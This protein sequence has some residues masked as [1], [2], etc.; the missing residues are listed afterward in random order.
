MYVL[1]DYHYD[2]PEERIAQVPV[3][4]RDQSRLLV[5]NR[6]T[7]KTTHC[8]FSDLPDLLLAGDLLVINNTEVIPARLFGKKESGGKAELLFLDF[9]EAEGKR[10]GQNT[11]V[12]R[13]LIKSAKR[14]RPGT[15]LRFDDRF[16]GRVREGKNGVY[17]VEFAFEGDFMEALHR[18]GHIPLPPYIR[19]KAGIPDPV[20]VRSYQT[21]YASRKGAVAAPTAGLHF[22]P[23]LLKNLAQKGVLTAEITLH[24]GYGTFLP[25]RVTDIRNHR[26]DAERYNVSKEAAEKIREAKDRGSRIVA[27]GTTCVRTLEYASDPKGEVV[28]GSGGCDLFI[29]PGCRFKVVE[30]LITNFHLPKSTLLMLVSAFAGRERILAA[31]REAVERRYRFY[32]FGDAMLIL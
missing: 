18:L 19:R 27:V 5:L 4:Q 17:E 28:P 1:E 8:R 26:M 30:A 11:A 20:D 16:E 15:R 10:S 3:S 23:E 21:V 14:P 2:L 24:V 32:S 29:Y 7:E 6:K 25:V 9:Q 31:Y 12:C 22:T 13:C